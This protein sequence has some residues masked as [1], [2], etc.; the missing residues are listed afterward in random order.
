VMT[1]LSRILATRNLSR[2]ANPKRSVPADQHS[3]HRHL[4]HSTRH[5][6]LGTYKMLLRTKTKY[7]SP[8]TTTIKGKPSLLQVTTNVRNK[9]CPWQGMFVI[10][11][12]LVRK[13]V[14]KTIRQITY[15]RNKGT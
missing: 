11:E 4:R 14:I 15:V 12:I 3:S 1:V 6:Y 8:Y 7:E 13:F 5:T 9:R 10:H 2:E